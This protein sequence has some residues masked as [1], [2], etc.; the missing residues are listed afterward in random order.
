MLSS[1]NGHLGCFHVL[2]IVKSATITLD[3]VHLSFQITVFSEYTPKSGIA[4]SY[5][6]LFSVF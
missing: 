3:G 6:V 2:A 5:A 1:V 4:E